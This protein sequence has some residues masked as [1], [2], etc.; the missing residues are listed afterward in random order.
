MQLLKQNR[1]RICVT[2]IM[3][4]TKDIRM[5]KTFYFGTDRFN[6]KCLT[7]KTNDL[8]LVDEL[9]KKARM[10]AATYDIHGVFYDDAPRG[11]IFASCAK[12]EM[13]RAFSNWRELSKEEVYATLP[14]V[15]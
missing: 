2:V 1:R 3:L 10:V 4:E 5:E 14:K 6:K 12:D 13:A 11:L 15:S 7:I 8:S 9:R